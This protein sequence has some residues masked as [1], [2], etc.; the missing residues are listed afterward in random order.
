VGR[1]TEF[2]YV[3]ARVQAR[4][5]ERP[6][7]PEWSQLTSIGS[8]SHFLQAAR[9]GPLRRWIFELGPHSG[10]D[11]MEL[12]LRR[13]FR[14]H[15]LELARWMPPAWRPAVRWV[16]H[17]PDL[18]AL[19]HLLAGNP[20][21]HWVQ[22]DPELRILDQDVVGR[23]RQ[24]LEGTERAPLLAAT[25]GPSTI[26]GAWYRHWHSL[27]P[28]SHGRSASHLREVA[29][30]VIR[31]R[32]LLR[33]DRIRQSR[34]HLETLEERLN[35]LFRRYSHEPAAVFAHLALTALLMERLRGALAVRMLFPPGDTA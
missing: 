15:V 4:H 7:G 27:W 3:Q 22:D 24:S 30:T 8:L 28:E 14:Y 16:R 10:I 18:P 11:E 26:A 23:R 13:H 6:T 35:R 34:P 20:A 32:T 1:Y 29:D 5:G 31:A 19:A 2:A 21:P 9:K 33:S 25:D 17:V 12:T